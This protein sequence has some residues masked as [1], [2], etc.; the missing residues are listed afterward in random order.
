VTDCRLPERWLNDRRLLRLSDSAYRTFV[1]LMLWAVANRTDGIMELE[2]V[3]LIPRARRTDLPELQC[4]GLIKVTG[5]R[6]TLIDYRA[7]QTSRDELQVLENARRR[8]RIKK[9]RQRAAAKDDPPGDHP[10]GQSPGTSLGTGPRDSTG[11]QEGRQEGTYDEAEKPSREGAVDAAS[12]PPVRPIPAESND[13]LSVQER[14]RLACKHR[15]Q[16]RQRREAVS[17]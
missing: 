11:R 4:Q 1:Q 9:A 17:G 2:D 3:D 10:S 15:V 6:L 14:A 8:E 7:T 5:Q 16:E 12:W 13:G